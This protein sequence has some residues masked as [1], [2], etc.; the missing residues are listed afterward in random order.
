M[1]RV[2]Y[3]VYNDA[4]NIIPY[5]AD[6]RA[7][8][9]IVNPNFPANSSM[10]LDGLLVRIETSVDWPTENFTPLMETMRGVL[11]LFPKIVAME[12]T[13]FLAMI[14][15]TN[16]TCSGPRTLSATSLTTTRTS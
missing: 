1:K 12:H 6:V 15:L 16:T 8:I 10:P 9:T 14:T 7:R 4:G 11:A 5:H 2:L 13:F 3:D